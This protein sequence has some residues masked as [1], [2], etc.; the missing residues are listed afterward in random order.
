MSVA[1]VQGIKEVGPEMIAVKLESPPE[2]EAE[3]GQF[4]LVKARID[5]EIESEYY[6]LSSPLVGETLEITAKYDS[7]GTVSPWLADRDFDGEIEIEITGPFGDIQYTG[8]HDVIIMASGPGIGPA[9]G[10]TERARDTDSAATIIYQTK[11]PAFE[12]R[13]E[14]L[15]RRKA[16]IHIVSDSDD[17][18]DHI[19]A[20]DSNATVYV[21]G[22]SAFI[23]SARDALKAAE[24]DSESVYFENYGPE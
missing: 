20:T 24:I 12:D 17:L 9:V 7:S 16:Q 6:M 13:L 15:A 22:F 10:I 3:P 8:G 18:T 11:T 2:F 1:T 19:Q 23:S 5:G 21:F 14:E 4:V